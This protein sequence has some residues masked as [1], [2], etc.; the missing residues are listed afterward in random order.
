[1]RRFHRWAGALFG[2]FLLWISATGLL[3][4]VGG[5]VNNGGFEKQVVATGQR[6]AA[7]I[8]D[9]IIAPAKAHEPEAA[10]P[11]A[12]ACPA[13]MICRPKPV[14]KPG[15]WNLGLL[16]HLHSGEQFGPLGVV[17]SMLSGLALFFFALSGLYMYIQMYRGRLAR[18][19][20]GR[21][22]RGGRFF[23]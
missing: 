19:E 18:S 4:Q 8:G 5:L 7:A 13:D 10:A 14:P 3:S 16:H 17:V 2:I 12:F 9:A 11:T 20:S 6:Q 21:R 1:M 23:W 22:T 15:A